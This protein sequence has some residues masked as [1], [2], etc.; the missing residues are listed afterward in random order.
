MIQDKRYILLEEGNV[1]TVL[2]SKDEAEAYKQR[3]KM[4]FPKL[5][6]KIVY[7]EYYEY[8]EFYSDEEQEQIKRLI[9]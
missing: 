4:M 9:P 6:Y 8:V 1:H 2:L 7:D 3:F 5:D